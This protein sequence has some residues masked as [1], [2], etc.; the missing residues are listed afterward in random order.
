MREQGTLVCVAPT[1]TNGDD[2]GIRYVATEAGHRR[3]G[4]ASRLLLAVMADA[5]AAG[6]RS[7]TLQASPAGLS[8][9]ER[10]G[11]RRVATMRGYLRPPAGP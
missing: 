4:L 5:R 1:L 8:V 10:L 2:V 7:A 9:Y 6:R 11:F 3:R